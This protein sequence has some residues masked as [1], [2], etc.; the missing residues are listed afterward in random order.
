LNR[1]VSPL[2][3]ENLGATGMTKI[4]LLGL[5]ENIKRLKKVRSFACGVRR[6]IN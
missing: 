6:G 1:H 4:I 5:T 3:P 2:Y